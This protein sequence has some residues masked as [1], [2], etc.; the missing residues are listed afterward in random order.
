MAN[1]DPNEEFSFS[2]KSNLI[3]DILFLKEAKNTF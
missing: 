2:F 1:L 3:S